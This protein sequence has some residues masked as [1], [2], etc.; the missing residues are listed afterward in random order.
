MP[1]LTE[2]VIIFLDRLY[3]HSAPNGAITGN[4]F[5]R[6]SSFC[7][8][9]SNLVSGISNRLPLS[10]SHT[11][12]QLKERKVG[13]LVSLQQPEGHE[14][15]G[16]VRNENSSALSADDFSEADRCGYMLAAFPHLRAACRKCY[17][18]TWL[19]RDSLPRN[20][21]AV[22]FSPTQTSTNK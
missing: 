1:L 20:W 7:F 2:L 22:T 21:N 5:F 10:H 4:P 15:D 17:P 16:A 8:R 18:L 9:S 6:T 11:I 13:K 3:E 12:G 19:D 14:A